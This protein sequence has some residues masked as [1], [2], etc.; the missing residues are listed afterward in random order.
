MRLTSVSA[1]K[2]SICSIR[3]Q[4]TRWLKEEDKIK[5]SIGDYAL[6]FRHIKKNILR[7]TLTRG[8][9]AKNDSWLIQKEVYS[10]LHDCNDPNSIYVGLED[11]EI[12]FKFQDKLL[13]RITGYCLTEIDVVK[14]STLNEEPRIEVVKTVDGQRTRIGNLCPYIDRKAYS[15]SVAFSIPSD[16]GIFGF[17]QDE[18]G[19]YNRRGTKYYLYQ[20][21]MRTPMPFMMTNKGYGI[22]FD[23]PSLMIFDD[24]KESTHITF[25]TVDQIDFY[26]ITGNMDD[27]I[28]EF[29]Y[30]TGKA[31]LLPKWAF[32][33]IQS[34]ERY[35][36]QFEM[37]DTA[38]R[39]REIGVPLD[40]IVQ[41][42]KTWPDEQWGQK[43]VD[44]AR[45]PDLAD[46]NRKLH[47]MNVHSMI[48]IWPN[49]A[50]GCADHTE[51]AKAGY[52]LGDYSTYNAF[53][54]NARAMYWKQAEKELYQG[55]F[56]SWWCDST[57]P[58]AAP[59]WCGETLLPEE[60]RYELVGGEHKKYLDPALA[61]I[62][63]L[64]HAKGIY[65]NQRKMDENK[66]V[67]NLTR[68]GYAGI[69]KYGVALWAGDPPAKWDE[70][71][72]EI[73]KGLN[74]CMSGIPFWTVDIGAFF[75]GGTECWRKWCGNKD[76]KQVWFWNGDYDKGV[77]SPAYRELYTRWL[78]FG[79][80]LP[81]FRSHGT[82]TPREI[83]NFGKPGDMFYDSIEKFIKLRYRL[84]PY[85]YSMA[86]RVALDDYTM[87]RSLMFDFSNDEKVNNIDDQFMF[88]D[89]LLVCPVTRPLYF[90][91]EGAIEEE[92]TKAC[93]LPKGMGWYDFWT[94]E[95]YKAGQT[96]TADARI[97]TM[98]IFVKAGSIL[99][100]QKET[101][102]AMEDP[103]EL[104]VW[105]YEGADAEGLYYNDDGVSYD[106][107]DG[108][109]ECIQF[110]WD[111]SKKRLAIKERSKYCN[112]SLKL[113]IH[114]GNT[115]K[116]V[117]YK[118]G[119]MVINF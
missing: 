53:D 33:Y 112:K 116:S 5:Y 110:E 58:F 35:D 61:N 26:L 71:K 40:C 107:K 38:K 78:Q 16:T 94:S 62:Y 25:D 80:F 54:E 4:N 95:F 106:Y 81:L 37:V 45:Y 114:F 119:D 27:I 72:R 115:V 8:N 77:E 60:K 96:V 17:G 83:W 108:R 13:L 75:A 101:H 31:E 49:M 91:R 48:S 28:S 10:Q 85:I 2:E 109:Y 36:T 20:H 52:L 42:W 65:E 9:D 88:G 100:M 73:S 70:L 34:R 59:D 103:G 30:L 1:K 104:E 50:V 79:T 98:P 105:I 29:R 57:E 11:E 90:D 32:G 93:Y 44:K 19:I 74:M 86:M 102:Y 66:R 41:D 67:F 117:R 89:A 43:T 63:A 113:Q 3:K 22:L 84:M 82:D 99:F 6:F 64:M 14:Y 46:M 47:E 97:D 7:C 69:Q 87:M 118:G 21:N 24:T 76:A 12:I 68:S 15:G 92:K 56:D 23:C 51:L 55:G 18:E 39:Y 111:N